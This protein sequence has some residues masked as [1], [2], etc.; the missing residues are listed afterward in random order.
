MC[1]DFTTETLLSQFGLSCNDVHY[2]LSCMTNIQESQD[3]IG[4]TMEEL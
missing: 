1:P 4:P 2:K 3:L